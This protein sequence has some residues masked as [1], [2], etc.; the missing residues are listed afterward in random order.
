MARES[1]TERERERERERE[2]HHHGPVCLEFWIWQQ[3]QG[4]CNP[5]MDISPICQLCLRSYWV[6]CR[7]PLPSPLTPSSS[8]SLQNKPPPTTHHYNKSNDRHKQNQQ[9]NELGT[10]SFKELSPYPREW[11]NPA[12]SKISNKAKIAWW[13]RR[14]YVC[15]TTRHRSIANTKMHKSK[16]VPEHWSVSTK[17]FSL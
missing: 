17:C 15:N 4:R 14:E 13:R 8:W 1:V 5:S 3:A 11:K 7:I 16:R 9:H 12:S 2:D 10:L 6:S